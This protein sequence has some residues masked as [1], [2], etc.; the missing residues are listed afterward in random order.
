MN[1]KN[2]LSNTMYFLSKHKADIAII[3]AGLL[4]LMG[5]VAVAK[6]TPKAKT[7]LT[8]SNKKIECLKRDIKDDDKIANNEIN[9]KQAKKEIKKIEMHTVLNF[10]KD[11]RYAII[12]G[13]GSLAL[14][15]FSWKVNRNRQM[16]LASAYLAL[17][18]SFKEYRSRVAN[19]FGDAVENEI[20]KNI[21]EEN[22]KREIID[23]NGNK[24]VINE[25]KM[26]AHNVPE[27]TLMFDASSKLWTK[28]GRTN[29]ETLCNIQKQLNLDLRAKHHVTIMDVI[30]A[31]LIPKTTVSKDILDKAYTWG[32]IYDPYDDRRSSWISFG[33][34]YENGVMNDVGTAL[35]NGDERDCWIVLNVDGDI[36]TPVDENGEKRTTF[37]DYITD[38]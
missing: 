21:Y 6:E 18:Q 34:N 15:G 35:Y 14:M 20:N 32:W 17:N 33:I 28:N 8:L 24:R 37:S 38:F 23:E 7:N 16:A 25:T 26:V 2:I 36:V 13:A 11:Y 27:W 19:R 5:F 12:C 31:L 3:G 29:Y 1:Y 4:E 22:V 10:V 30:N 9:V